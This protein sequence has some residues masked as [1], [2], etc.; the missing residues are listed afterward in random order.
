M[1]YLYFTLY[2]F[3]VNIIKLHKQYPPIVNVTAV[4]SVLINFIIFSVIKIYY[5]NN[6][7]VNYNI[8]IYSQIIF[9]FIIWRL[10]YIYYKPR[11][12]KLLDKMNEKD[13]W[14]KFI[15]VITS[16]LF[17]IIAVKLWMF[18]GS[19]ELYKYFKK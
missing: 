13:F 14:L 7:F 16:F 17:I 1:K 9:T 5:F 8:S 2:L 15:I 10:L 11:E 3:Y 6:D 12:V 19:I 18:D 4:M